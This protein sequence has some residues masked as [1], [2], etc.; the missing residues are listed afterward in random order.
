MADPADLANPPVIRPA[1]PPTGFGTVPE[2]ARETSRVVRRQDRQLIICKWIC[3]PFLAA[4]VA[5]ALSQLTSL[6]SAEA[7]LGLTDYIER[8]RR[9]LTDSVDFTKRTTLRMLRPP[10]GRFYT[11]TPGGPEYAATQATTDN[12]NSISITRSA[13]REKN[14]KEAARLADAAKDKSDKRKS[15]KEYLRDS[16][17][18]KLNEKRAS[19]NGDDQEADQRAMGDL[20][21]SI[22]DLQEEILKENEARYEINNII[23]S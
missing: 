13:R 16:Q 11:G 9:I 22:Q 20:M 3:L 18:A 15:E 1:N 6:W 17:Q 4:S 10:E 5:L 12:N 7:P 23:I 19:N 21:R 14:K 2:D 8:T